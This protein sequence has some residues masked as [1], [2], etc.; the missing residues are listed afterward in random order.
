V[1]QTNQKPRSRRKRRSGGPKKKSQKGDK[2]TRRDRKKRYLLRFG[3]GEG[4]GPGGLPC[5]VRGHWKEKRAM[6]EEKRTT[7]NEQDS[8]SSSCR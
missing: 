5:S 3:T 7:G 6:G 4:R 1:Y 2:R 8:K